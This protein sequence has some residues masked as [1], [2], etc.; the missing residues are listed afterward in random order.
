[1]WAAREWPQ[2]SQRF[3]V[4]SIIISVKIMIHAVAKPAFA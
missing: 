4:F 3:G 1:M 2:S